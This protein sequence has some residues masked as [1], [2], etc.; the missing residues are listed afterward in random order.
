MCDLT[1]ELEDWYAQKRQRTFRSGTTA[2]QD[3]SEFRRLRCA[4]KRL[5]VRLPSAAFLNL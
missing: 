5:G 2:L 3:R 1:V 4:A